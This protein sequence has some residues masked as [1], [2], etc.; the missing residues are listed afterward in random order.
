MSR[1]VKPLRVQPLWARVDQNR[2]KLVAFVV[3]FVLGS[4]VLLTAAL[5]ALPAS[6]IGAFGAYYEGWWG[7]AAYTEGFVTVVLAG[8]GL[9]ILAGA[10]IAAVQLHS[11]GHRRLVLR[12]DL[13]RCDERYAP[14]RARRGPAVC[15]TARGSRHGWD[16]RPAA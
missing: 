9:F 15:E 7:P 14:G 1:P 4:S 10:F 12:R 5:V 13:L 16:C 6:L 2:V 11:S 8:F 3:F